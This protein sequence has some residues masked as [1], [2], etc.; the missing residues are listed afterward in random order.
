MPDL[1]ADGRCIAG[2]NEGLWLR[3]VAGAVRAWTLTS[4]VFC[5]VQEH[6]SFLVLPCC[7]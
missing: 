3:L 2:K 1:D 4:Y 7:G 6:V 5:S